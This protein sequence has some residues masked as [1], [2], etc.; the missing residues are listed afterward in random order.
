MLT[1]A[2]L[3]MLS[4][5]RIEAIGNTPGASIGTGYFYNMTAVGDVIFPAIITNKHV[6]EGAH[7]INLHLQIMPGG[8]EPNDDGT[9][10]GEQR[11]PISMGLG[12]LVIPHPDPNVDLCAIMIAQ[13]V[14]ALPEG[15]VLKHMFLDGTWRLNLD[16]SSYVRPIEPVL[17]VGYPN[18]LWDQVNNRPITRQ[19]STASH[20]LHNWNGERT[21]VI[22]AACF[23]GS[24]GS[25]VFLYEDGMFRSRNNSYSPGTRARL[26][27]TLYAGPLVTAEGQL[28]PRPIPTST[29]AVPQINLMMNLGYVVKADAIDDL[30]AIVHQAHAQQTGS[31]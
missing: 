26:L 6:I 13:I 29:V 4:T 12:N 9:A 23:G 25:P 19:G 30:I 10:S 15:M 17:M 14:N 22:D 31:T 20:P 3:L 1:P 27:G 11:W 16:E 8:T 28:V 24:S 18:G 21:F 5:T 7:T 2:T